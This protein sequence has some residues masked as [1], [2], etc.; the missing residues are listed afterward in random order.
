[1]KKLQ[2]EHFNLY[3]MSISQIYKLLY[4]GYGSKELIVKRECVR[5]FAMFF[6]EKLEGIDI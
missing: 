5:Y 3:N 1:M 4:D 2:G 6:T